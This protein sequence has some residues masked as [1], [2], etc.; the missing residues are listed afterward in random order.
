MQELHIEVFVAQPRQLA[1]AISQHIF[2]TLT[3]GVIHVVHTVIEL[4]VL[5][6]GI[7]SLHS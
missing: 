6:N 1:M 2:P 7:S 5:Q 3:Y 4:Q